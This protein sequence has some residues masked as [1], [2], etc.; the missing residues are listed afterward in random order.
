MENNLTEQLFLTCFYYVWIV[1]PLLFAIFYVSLIIAERRSG[2]L[3]E[4]HLLVKLDRPFGF[5]VKTLYYKVYKDAEAYKNGVYEL[6]A[7]D[8]ICPRRYRNHASLYCYSVSEHS[9]ILWFVFI[10]LIMPFTP[11]INILATFFVIIFLLTPI[12]KIRLI[13]YRS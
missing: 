5:A 6:I 13:K 4:S 11:M 12:A 2:P 1:V 8:Y 10:T 9:S 3:P 7:H